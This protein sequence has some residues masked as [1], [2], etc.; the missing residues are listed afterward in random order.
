MNYSWI[1][2]SLSNLAL[3]LSGVLLL[4]PYA[5]RSLS[6][7]IGLSLIA[8]PTILSSCHWEITDSLSLSFSRP[9]K[10]NPVLIRGTFNRRSAFILQTTRPVRPCAVGVTRASRL[11]LLSHACT[12]CIFIS[13]GV[14]YKPDPRVPHRNISNDSNG[15]EIFACLMETEGLI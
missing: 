14:L 6:V 11:H 2:L 10:K 8:L 3:W 7:C 9:N 4:I 5:S 1:F 12:P 13:D 15:C